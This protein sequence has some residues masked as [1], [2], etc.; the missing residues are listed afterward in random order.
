[1]GKHYTDQEL[2]SMI[3][4]GD[5]KAE[6]NALCFLKNRDSEK[7]I[8][9][10]CAHSGKREDGEEIFNDALIALWKNIRSGAYRLSESA[11]MG[12]YLMVIVKNTWHKELRKQG[13][14]PPLTSISEYDA[15]IREAE[16]SIEQLLIEKERN[17]HFR[18]I[19]EMTLNEKEKGILKAFYIE[20]LSMQEV[21][22]KFGLGNA[23]NA[24][25]HRYQIIKK[26]KKGLDNHGLWK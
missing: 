3:C 8:K 14:L 7:A 19:F 9:Y 24:K 1:M 25:S 26:L 5:T 6:D 11:A 20:G 10:V 21:A 2:V 4:S 16:R 22:D 18:K 12:T 23:N 13:R 17:D 15:D